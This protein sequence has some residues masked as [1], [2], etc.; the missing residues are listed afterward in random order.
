MP[1]ENIM[2]Y[3][4]RNNPSGMFLHFPA[5][6]RDE[7]PVGLMTDPVTHTPAA[8]ETLHE[9]MRAAVEW[10]DMYAAKNRDT[11]LD[12]LTIVEAYLHDEA[13]REVVTLEAGREVV[14]LPMGGHRCH[15][16]RS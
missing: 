3:L 1:R 7:Y 16:L 8:F 13:G 15:R 4:I 10:L 6:E 14:N 9:A 5:D 2:T 12:H 11:G